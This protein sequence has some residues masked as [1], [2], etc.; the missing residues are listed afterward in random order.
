MRRKCWWISQFNIKLVKVRRVL[1]FVKLLLFWESMFRLWPGTKSQIWNISLPCS[2]HCSSNW[3]CH[4]QEH[5]TPQNLISSPW[6]WGL[7]NGWESLK[8]FVMPPSHSTGCHFSQ[9]CLQ[10]PETWMCSDWLNLRG[11]SISPQP[12]IHHQQGTC[13]NVFLPWCPGC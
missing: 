7:I 5:Q 4:R 10:I 11:V 13:R 9:L 8:T 6:K 3:N 12:S 1:K 2:F